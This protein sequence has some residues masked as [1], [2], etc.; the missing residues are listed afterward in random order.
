AIRSVRAGRTAPSA[1]PTPAPTT[2]SPEVA[3]E[4]PEA[5][6]QASIPELESLKSISDTVRVDIRKLDD[7]MNLVGELVITRGSIG[8]L[9]ARLAAQGDGP[10]DSSRIAG[11]FAK[12]HKAL[13]RKLREL[14]SAVLEVRMVPLRQVFEKVSRVVRRLRRE[15]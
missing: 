7:L 15:L 1:A 14:Q 10:R 6:T 13:D 11:E 2:A 12:V 8:D 3:A 9:I 4:E 5:E